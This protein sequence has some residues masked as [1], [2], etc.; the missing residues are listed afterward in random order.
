MLKSGGAESKHFEI[1]GGR[2]PPGPPGS[3]AYAHCVFCVSS[4]SYYRHLAVHVV[5]S[6]T[7]GVVC[8]CVCGGGGGGAGT[9]HACVGQ[10]IFH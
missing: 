10:Y 3:S 4:Y 9:V 8:V 6:I 5:Q 2:G 1:W 7:A